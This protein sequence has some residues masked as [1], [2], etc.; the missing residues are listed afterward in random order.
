MFHPKIIYDRIRHEK[1]PFD[2]FSASQE[3]SKRGRGAM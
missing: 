1:V 3:M 2:F